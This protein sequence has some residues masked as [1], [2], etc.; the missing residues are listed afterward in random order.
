MAEV[1]FYVLPYLKGEE[2][3]DRIGEMS[4]LKV[5]QTLTAGVENFLA[6]CSRTA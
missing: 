2:V 3:L 4:R 5:I 6:T 1:E